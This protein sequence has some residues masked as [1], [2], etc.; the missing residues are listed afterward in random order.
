MK[1]KSLTTVILV[2]CVLTLACVSRLNLQN[3]KASS[4]IEIAVIKEVLNNNWT[5]NTFAA[6]FFD[7]SPQTVGVLKKLRGPSMPRFDFS[8]RNLLT[9]ST[10]GFTDRV[11]M[12]PALKVYAKVL[13][14]SNDVARAEGGAGSASLSGFGRT[15]QLKQA[16][17]NWIIVSRGERAISLLNTGQR[18]IAGR[19]LA[20]EYHNQNRLQEFS[21]NLS[22]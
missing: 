2:T 22:Q 20:R 18:D 14:I 5:T 15:Y 6:L 10:N 1:F 12:K 16:G 9:H 19:K 8:N 4:E 11:T 21:S 13:S 3:K 17:T 7:V